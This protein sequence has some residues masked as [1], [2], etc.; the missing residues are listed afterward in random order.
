MHVIPQCNIHFLC[1]CGHCKSLAP[2]YERAAEVLAGINI[3]LAKVDATAHSSLGSRFGVSGYPT[4]K[5]F[6]DGVAYDYEGPRS[7]T[8]R[9]SFY[10]KN[11]IFQTPK[12]DHLIPF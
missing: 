5:V 11:Q 6:H 12:Y 10:S 1:R 9:E 8:G 4:L 2:E 7:A 3:P